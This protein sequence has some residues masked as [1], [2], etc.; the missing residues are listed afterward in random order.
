VR[1]HAVKWYSAASA[2]RRWTQ[3]QHAQVIL[4]YSSQKMIMTSRICIAQCALHS[5]CTVA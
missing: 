3:R 5:T 1:H 4:G 2:R